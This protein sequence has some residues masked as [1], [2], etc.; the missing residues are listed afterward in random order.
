MTA[1]QSSPP[2]PS[3]MAR[4]SQSFG[5][6]NGH[7]HQHPPQH[8]P[9]IYTAVYSGVSV[10]EMEVGEGSD[11]VAV[12]RRRSDSWLN[13]TQILKVAAVDKG[14]RTKI[15]E[16]E[17]HQGVHEKVQGGYGRYQGTWISYE[18]GRQFCRQY[19]VEDVLRPLLEYDIGSDGAGMRSTSLETPTKEQ[20]MAANRQRFYNNPNRGERAHSALG[21]NTFFQGISPT[22]SNAIA[23]MTKA[24][25]YD[26]GRPPSSNLR[27]TP[28]L[29][30]QSSSQQMDSQGSVGGVQ[31]SQE[32]AAGFG[33]GR[34]HPDLNG[35]GMQY[36]SQQYG[37]YDADGLNE[38]PRKRMRPDSSQDLSALD[39]ALNDE[40][41]T[42]VNESFVQSQPLDADIATAMPPL[43][44]SADNATEVKRAALLALF[45]DN[46]PT[47]PT[48][49][50]ALQSLSGHD[51]DVPLDTSA[52]TA[53]H[54]A[55]TLA[56]VSIMR[57]LINRGANMYQGNA[58]N[59]TPLM[60][61]VQVNNCYD[62][63]CFPEVLDTLGPLIDVR[64]GTG[65]TVLHHIAVSSGI[66]G[67]STSARYYLESLLEYT[68]K[69][70]GPT[71]SSQ[72]QPFMNGNGTQKKQLMTL[73]KF[74]STVVN[75]QDRS[76]NTA[77]N[78]VARVGNRTIIN[79]LEEVGADFEIANNLGFKPRD[80]GI[81][82]R[83][84]QTPQQS[85]T[86]E[87]AS[88]QESLP[89]SQVD[90]IKEEIVATTNTIL[91]QTHSHY[92]NEL[93]A[94][95]SL[96]ASQTAALKSLAAEHDSEAAK[97]SQLQQ[98]ERDRKD[99]RAKMENHRRANDERRGRVERLKIESERGRWSD[100]PTIN[101]ANIDPALLSSPDTTNP[102]KAHETA[103]S[104]P[105]LST[106][107]SLLAAH[108]NQN[109][110]LAHHLAKLHQQSADQESKYRK[111]VSLCTGVEEEEVDGMLGALLAAVASEGSLEVGRVRRFLRGAEGMAGA[112]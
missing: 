101:L 78:L 40:T 91:T 86:K 71:S 67:R 95:S 103:S 4:G 16:K 20:A 61:A 102:Q 44:A 52:N 99:R 36:G 48:S 109:S 70:G 76:G 72:Q 68:V 45:E 77:L 43:S 1:T 58:A 59:Q 94:K 88:S 89:A 80:F 81:H 8:A 62:F 23:A 69:Q 38:P 84:N 28:S 63:S 79:Q 26:G 49:H 3:H 15:L 13:A 60:A 47:D 96:I 54:W 107:T 34:D 11:K 41:P 5:Q 53:L 46:A 29:V 93:A 42:E 57:A 12:M 98:R 74:M 105:S 17:I 2:H 37:A 18:R 24:A 55:A 9:Q 22:T 65:R 110:T 82:P 92:A 19:G 64:D 21:G 51:F 75:A 7:P 112:S 111:V 31:A 33:H 35:S 106:L 108:E 39:P 50:P 27:K 97:L 100:T 32:S 10:Y 56:R 85:M 6:P 104:L 30:R 83:N 73:T 25:K 14:R 87:E 90:Q 66:K